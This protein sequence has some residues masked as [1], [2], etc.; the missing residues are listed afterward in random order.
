MRPYAGPLLG[1][2]STSPNNS[3][4][5]DAPA[6]TGFAAGLLYEHLELKERLG[7]LEE[8]LGG[9][10]RSPPGPGDGAGP[11]PGRGARGGSA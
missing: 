1:L 3:C 7:P 10:Q 5:I 9:G 4:F 8:A 11:L 6:G 2:S